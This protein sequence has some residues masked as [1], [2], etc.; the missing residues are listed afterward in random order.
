MDRLFGDCRKSPLKPVFER[1]AFVNGNRSNLEVADGDIK[2][3]GNKTLIQPKPLLT[4][5]KLF[6]NLAAHCVLLL[7]KTLPWLLCVQLMPSIV[8]QRWHQIC[9]WRRMVPRLF[10]CSYIQWV[11]VTGDLAESLF[12]SDKARV[13]CYCSVCLENKRSIKMTKIIFS[14]VLCSF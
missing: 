8:A 1:I 5:F 13:N 3:K 12:R 9:G 11:I 6:L 2:S 4:S 10:F 7:R 14:Q